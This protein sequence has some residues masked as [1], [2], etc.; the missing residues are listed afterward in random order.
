MAT[1]PPTEPDRI[2]PQSPPDVLP[3]PAEPSE[4]HP[5]ENEPLAPDFDQPDESPEEFPGA[6]AH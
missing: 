2:E 3:I 5:D 1:Q 6:G 4:P